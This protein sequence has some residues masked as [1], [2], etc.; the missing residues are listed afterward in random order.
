MRYAENKRLLWLSTRSVIRS[1]RASHMKWLKS[2]ALVLLSL[3][4][5]S[6][7][8]PAGSIPITNVGT[9]NLPDV[10]SIDTMMVDYFLAPNRKGGGQFDVPE[11]YYAKILSFFSVHEQRE[12]AQTPDGSISTLQAIAEIQIMTKDGQEI[13]IVAYSGDSSGVDDSYYFRVNGIYNGSREYDG[14]TEGL[15]MGNPWGFF[16]SPLDT[17]WSDVSRTLAR[18]QQYA[19]RDMTRRKRPKKDR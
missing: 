3:A 10:A 16:N 8:Q 12:T 19:A 18:A 9:V 5:C 17:R 15:S 6:E 2:I 7:K 4:G 11:P 1:D 14:W 13:R